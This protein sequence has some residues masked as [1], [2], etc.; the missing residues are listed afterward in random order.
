DGRQTL[1]RQVRGG[2]RD[3]IFQQSF[4]GN[5]LCQKRM[6]ARL[7][8]ADYAVSIFFKSQRDGVG[9]V[10]CC[11]KGR[12]RLQQKNVIKMLLLRLF[13]KLNGMKDDGD[14]RR[15]VPSE[16]GGA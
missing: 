7:R 4:T 3:E 11:A 14:M 8:H 1:T 16:R 5:A 9:D 2:L 6:R 15:I 13:K 10:G 12:C